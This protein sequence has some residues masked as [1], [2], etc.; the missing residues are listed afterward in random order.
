MYDKN[1]MI[2]KIKK[3]WKENPRWGGIKRPYSAEEVIQLKGSTDIE[4]TLAKLGAEKF[5]DLLMKDEVVCAL[6]A[7]TGNQ[8]VQEVQVGM[9]SFGFRFYVAG[10]CCRR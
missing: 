2:E 6:G 9:K 4:Y 1:I 5:W 7:L 8:A 10:C 3:D